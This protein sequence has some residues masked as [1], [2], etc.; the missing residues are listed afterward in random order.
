MISDV[1]IK[2]LEAIKKLSHSLQETLMKVCNLLS[3]VDFSCHLNE[4]AEITLT[5]E[6]IHM[7]DLATQVGKA[8]RDLMGAIDETNFNVESMN[9]DIES[10]FE[11]TKELNTKQLDTF[12]TAFFKGVF[13][14]IVKEEAINKNVLIPS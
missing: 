3:Y 5:I 13:E 8:I 2:Q 9:S 12:S 1:L 10:S 6:N 14:K 7:S 11:P 4:L